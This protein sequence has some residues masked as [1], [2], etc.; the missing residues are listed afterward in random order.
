MVDGRRI[1]C[2]LGPSE[3]GA[4]WVDRDGRGVFLDAIDQ[5]R[6]VAAG[7]ELLVE[8]SK[9]C[10]LVERR[11]PSRDQLSLELFGGGGS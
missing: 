5:A 6:A 10:R 8:H 4:V 7:E 2:D 11:G 1:A 9:T 3:R